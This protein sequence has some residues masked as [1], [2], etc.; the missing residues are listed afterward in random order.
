[1]LLGHMIISIHK[2]FMYTGV[3]YTL[4]IIILIYGIQVSI[5]ITVYYITVSLP[6]SSPN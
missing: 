4:N 3:F 5:E 6:S 1:M 2:I